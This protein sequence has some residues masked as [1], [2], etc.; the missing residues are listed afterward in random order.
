MIRLPLYV[1]T[2]AAL[3]ALV[4][5]TS[6]SGQGQPT[7]TVSPGA[8]I[9]LQ[10]TDDP[11][12]QVG[13]LVSADHDSIRWVPDGQQDKLLSMAAKSIAQLEVSRGQRGHTLAGIGIGLLPGAAIGAM[14]GSAASQGHWFAGLETAGYAVGGALG[15]MLVGGV[16]GAATKTDN[17]AK[18][19]L[20]R[21]RISIAPLGPGGLR[22][23]FV[24]R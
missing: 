24:L 12:W 2:G 5:Q 11:A 16:I 19:P 21:V 9:R 8:R 20:D 14:I 22:L 7:P 13:R 15:G 3:G 18:V 10:R 4:P 6:L 23:A 17:W 1:V